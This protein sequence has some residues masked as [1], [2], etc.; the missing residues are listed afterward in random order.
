MEFPLEAYPACS[1]YFQAAWTTDAIHIQCNTCAY[2]MEMACVISVA[3][4][5]FISNF[6]CINNLVSCTLVVASLENSF[7]VALGASQLLAS[8]QIL[9]A[10]LRDILFSVMV[11]IKFCFMKTVDMF[12]LELHMSRSFSLDSEL[13]PKS[14]VSDKWC[15]S[16]MY[17]AMPS[18]GSW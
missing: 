8:C 15:N 9:A 10:P 16:A 4:I 12:H 11:N 3:P 14:Q 17:D 6:P 13:I 5:M 7:W 2:I 1:T 18:S